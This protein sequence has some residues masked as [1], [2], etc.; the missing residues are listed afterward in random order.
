[1]STSRVFKPGQN[2]LSAIQTISNGQT[3]QDLSYTFDAN[4]NVTNRSDAIL[5]LSEDFGY[6]D[7]ERL[8]DYGV[9]GNRKTVS[10]YAN[11]NIKNKSDVGEYVYSDQNR[12]HALSKVTHSI[13][14]G[15]DLNE[16]KVNWEWDGAAE[17]SERTNVHNVDFTYDANG[18]ATQLGDRNLHWT[19]FD[20]PYLMTV[21]SS[22]F[23]DR[24]GSLIEYDASFNRVYKEKAKYNNSNVKIPGSETESTIYVGTDYEKI[25]KYSTSG[26][27]IIHRYTLSTG[28]NT[29]QI[30]RENNSS[31][32]KPK[33]M[34][35]DAL[36]STNVI[37]D[38]QLEVEQ[39]LAFDP[40]G[41]RMNVGDNSAV[42]KITTRGY[43][44]HEM[45]D[46]LGLI[47]MNARVY[48]PY[49]ARF[50]SADLLIPS[51]LNMQSYNRYSYVE[52]NPLTYFDPT[53]HRRAQHTFPTNAQ[54][55][56]NGLMSSL[57]IRSLVVP[58]TLVAGTVSSG[59]DVL[60]NNSKSIKLSS[61][62]VY[63]MSVA[64]II[65]TAIDQLIAFEFGQQLEGIL[66][67]NL[68]Q[69]KEV[70]DEFEKKE[71][72]TLLKGVLKEIDEAIEDLEAEAQSEA[73]EEEEAQSDDVSEE[74]ES[75]QEGIERNAEAV[76]N[77]EATERRRGL[78]RINYFLQMTVFAA[79][80]ETCMDT[81]RCSSSIVDLP[82]PKPNPTKDE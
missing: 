3:I 76:G 71:L 12:P 22:A 48:D 41:M 55:H 33:Y 78:R 65:G 81:G 9:V 1:M 6:D 75:S 64:A 17:L 8:T 25:T 37:L 24:R 79:P 82:L 77:T 61:K 11:G 51:P 59:G 43:T 16:F 72:T 67:L 62:I 7:L 50:L 56:V 27:E 69:L 35:S 14:N 21:S 49:L 54:R 58:F 10:Y 60:N 80:R 44:G 4:N 63:K 57:R 74:Q 15:P 53:G 42:N 13:T 31:V 68:D 20:K 70:R 23:S 5:G 32:D 38:N 28:S 40:W 39:R 52:G 36:G 73:D 46:E 34:L 45:D 18:N 29:I 26:N 30:E 66:E 2:V 19:A 47:N